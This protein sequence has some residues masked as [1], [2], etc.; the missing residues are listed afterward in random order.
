LIADQGL[1]D[2][3]YRDATEFFSEEEIAQ[4]IVLI[5]TINAWNRIGV[6]TEA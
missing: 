5:A 6:A 2:E 4:L 1:S 3:D